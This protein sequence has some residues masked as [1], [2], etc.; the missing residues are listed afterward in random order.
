VA[1]RWDSRDN[2]GV[3][4]ARRDL[5]RTAYQLIGALAED[6]EHPDDA[7]YVNATIDKLEARLRRLPTAAELAQEIAPTYGAVP[8]RI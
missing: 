7:R 1:A 5:I 8:A 6:S 3:E 2:S 4:D